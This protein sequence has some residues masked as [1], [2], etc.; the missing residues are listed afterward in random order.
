MG[1]KR[2]VNKLASFIKPSSPSF[3]TT[4]RVRKNTQKWLEEIL[5]ILRIPQHE[6]GGPTDGLGGDVE[7][8]VQR[9]GGGCTGSRGQASRWEA[10]RRRRGEERQCPVT[11]ESRVQEDSPS[12]LMGRLYPYAQESKGQ[13]C[14]EQVEVLAVEWS[15]IVGDGSRA[16][17][18]RP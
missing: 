4:E 1:M 9:Q 16:K 5:E 13:Q 8:R 15:R 11:I 14:P 12:I 10:S 7:R 18:L 3:I 2:Q 6:N 17:R